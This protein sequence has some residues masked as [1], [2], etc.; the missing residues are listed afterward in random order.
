MKNKK[1]GKCPLF[2]LFFEPNLLRMV[3]EEMNHNV[4]PLITVSKPNKE[5]ALST[6]VLK[7]SLVS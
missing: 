4:N 5:K 6:V 7:L 2:Y 3:G 1:G